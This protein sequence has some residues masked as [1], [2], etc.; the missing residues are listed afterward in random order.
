MSQQLQIPQPDRLELGKKLNINTRYK[1]IV[2]DPPLDLSN[3]VSELNFK[4]NINSSSNWMALGLCHKNTIVQ[5]SYSFP[6]SSTGK[7]FLNSQGHGAYMISSN[8]G[9]WSH[10]DS[11]WNNVVKAFK[12]TT[13]DIVNVKY[14]PSAQ[15][16]YFQKK[17]ENYTLKVN[18]TQPLNFLLLFHYGGD[19]VEI[20]NP[21]NL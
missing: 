8:A 6:Y 16:V 3:A 9:T 10:I 7:L 14:R 20:Q 2:I 18:D 15:T 13:G 4:I 5:N 19:E 17:N 11:A 21:N 1:F 12:F